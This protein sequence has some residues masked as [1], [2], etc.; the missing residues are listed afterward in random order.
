MDKPVAS[1]LPG[2]T[3]YRIVL[4]LCDLQQQHLILG[5]LGCPDFVVP[6]KNKQG[7]KDR[8]S[9]EF[10]VLRDEQ[11]EE[12]H[13]QLQYKNLSPISDHRFERTDRCVEPDAA[14]S[15]EL[16]NGGDSVGPEGT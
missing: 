2:Q 12:R 11:P 3:K 16:Y 6:R 8:N 13:W 10:P 4:N 14:S 9:N 7:P 1:C 15:Q 5:F